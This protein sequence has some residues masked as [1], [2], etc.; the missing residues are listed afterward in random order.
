MS[1]LFSTY[2]M[3]NLTLKNRVVMSP[4]CMYSVETDD[5]VANDFHLAHY[6]SRATGQVGLIILEAAAVQAVGRISHGDLGLW[7][8]AQIPALKR[9]VDGVHYHGAAVGIQLAHAGRKA[10]LD[11]D[12]VAPSAVPFDDDSKKPHELTATEIEEVVADFQKAAIRAKEAGFDVI[13][14]HAAHGYLLHEFLSPISNLRDDEYGGPAGNRYRV[15]SDVIKAIRE[16]WDGPLFVRVS[17]SDFAHGGLTVDDYIPFAKWM[18]ADGADLLDVSSG[19]LVNVAPKV[20]PGYQVPF[21]EK[22]RM[23]AGIATGVVGLITTGVQAEEILQN[24]RADLIF[25]G[26]ELL[27]DPYWARTAAKDVRDSVEAPKQYERGW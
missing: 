17:A 19:G 14:V 8:D 12:L 3:K 18:K 21:A 27:R 15:V 10:V 1:K 4:M 25:L 24:D 7:E 22:I 16:V 26:R 11:V 9:I 20:Y 2:K 23:G 5:G 13:E 6:V